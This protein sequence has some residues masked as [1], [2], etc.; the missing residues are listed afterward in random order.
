MTAM[1]PQLSVI[2]ATWG[3][4][5]HILPSIR[6]V[7]QQDLADFELLVVGDATRDET[8]AVVRGLDDPRVRWLNLSERVGSQSGPNNAGIAAA[9]AGIIAYLG[10]D[11]LW[12]PFHLSRV[13]PVFDHADRPDFVVSGLIAHDPHGQPGGRVYGL[14]AG[15]DDKHRHHFPPGCLAHRKAVIDRIGPWALP[16]SLRAP[17]DVD[18]LARAVAADLRFS[19]TGVVTVHRFSAADRY[20]S[21]VRPESDEQATLLAAFQD[22]G[23]AAR[24]A[25]IVAAARAS[26]RYMRPEGRD[27]SGR[28]PGEIAR[29]TAVR[30]GIA[31]PPTR[32]LGAG[33]TIRHRSE[34]GA[35]DWET[36]PV[37]GLRRHRRNPRPRLL[38]PVTASGPVLVRFRLHHPV[39]AA[40]DVLELSC[41][42][43]VAHAEPAAPRFGPMGRSARYDV[44]LTL[45]A[46]GPSI[47]EL[48]LTAAQQAKYR[49]GPFRLGLAI[50]PL[51]LRPAEIPD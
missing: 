11:D 21:Y 18:F 39:P 32:P 35:W 16:L 36:A 9:R 40:L 45:E 23:H 33:T 26:G 3:R 51:R 37:L 12:E 38:L 22:P 13:L 31:R 17:I 27:Y 24:V 34:D 14:I 42:G 30:R 25:G 48:R 46:E 5:R 49:I 20:L 28:T 19:G 2:M 4:G 41:N 44:R 50:G 10:H 47:L 6:S 29:Q 7:L 8:E 15:D 1:A 43:V